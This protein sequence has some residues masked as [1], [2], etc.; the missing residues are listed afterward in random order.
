MSKHFSKVRKNR[1]RRRELATKIMVLNGPNLNLL[2]TREPDL[3]G[4]DTLSD[5]CKRLKRQVES[6]SLQ[7]EALQTNAEHELVDA[8]HRAKIDGVG[9][10]I[11]NA[12]AFTHTSVAVRDA[13]L[14]VEIPFVEI[15]I[16]NVY[17]REAF[18]H[19]SYLSD[20]ARGV[21]VGFGTKGYGYAVEMAIDELKNG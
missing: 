2:G 18:R 19:Q 21:I 5:V 15:H 7:F 1:D 12:G 3:Y 11:I 14:G 10:I 6:H 9:F 17:A 16:S 8:I 13:L 4:H 20:I